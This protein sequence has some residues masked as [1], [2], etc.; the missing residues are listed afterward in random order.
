M[1]LTRTGWSAGIALVLALAACGDG[2]GGD[3]PTPTERAEEAFVIGVSVPR[4]EAGPGQADGEA[5]AAALTERGHDV[6]LEEAADAG[7]QA[8][9]VALLLDDGVDALVVTPVDPAGL[10]RALTDAAVDV[11]VVAYGRLVRE[12]PDVTYYTAFDRYRVGVHQANALLNGLGVT[13]LDGTPVPEP[14]PGPFAV[15]LF[16][17]SPDDDGARA[18]FNGAMDTLRPYLDNGTLSVVSGEVEFDDVATQDGDPGAARNRTARL[19]E[20]AYA[21]NGRLHA[22]LSPDDTM[23]L[24]VLEALEEAGYGGEDRPW[25]VVTGADAEPDAVRA[26]LEGRQFATVFKDPRDLANETAELVV[27]VLRGEEPEINDTES[28]DNGAV[29]VPAR[30]LGSDVV[31]RDNVR[32]VLV[33]S[34]A[35]SADELGL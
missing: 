29:V 4:G 13:G 26:I 22:V 6:R 24:A 11:P 21:G 12:S 5:L 33:D 15:E 20:E 14:P 19:L 31:V 17:G 28:Y 18:T 1:R 7:A 16:A 9:S 34:G 27:A 35:Y 3:A 2:G 30:L 10:G 25:P 32:Q 8:Q 23:S